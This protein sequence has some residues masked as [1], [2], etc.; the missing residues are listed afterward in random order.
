MKRI[1]GTLITLFFVI[2]IAS[3]ENRQKE[4]NK[5]EQECIQQILLLDQIARGQTPTP[6]STDLNQTTRTTTAGLD[7]QMMLLLS[8]AC[9]T[10][11]QDQTNK[12]LPLQ[13]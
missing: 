12:N 7:P 2:G 10:T 6:T 13:Q 11:G 9:G 1:I 3:C 5:D 8:V 4:D